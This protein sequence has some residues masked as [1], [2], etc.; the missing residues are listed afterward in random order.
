MPLIRAVV[1]WVPVLA[2]AG[3]TLTGYRLVTD[4]L[5]DAP[6][7]PVHARFLE[8]LAVESAQAGTYRSRYDAKFSR[9][10]VASKHFEQVCAAM[11][12]AALRD[13]VDP[14]RH[15]APIARS[16]RALVRKFPS[17][18]LPD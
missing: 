5:K 18:A 15:S 17:D 9:D 16:C 1:G 6:V 12:A 11:L 14:S 13:Q 7:E 2:F 8:F 4:R 10:T 3:L